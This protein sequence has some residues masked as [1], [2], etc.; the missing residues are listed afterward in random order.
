[1]ALI[2]AGQ[3]VTPA[4]SFTAGLKLTPYSP[5]SARDLLAVVNPIGGGAHGSAD[6]NPTIQRQRYEND[7]HRFNK[8]QIMNFVF[9]EA[10]KL[11]AT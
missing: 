1:M 6:N 9:V 7:T 3:V 8:N 10:P 2:I 11:T 5:A 4:L